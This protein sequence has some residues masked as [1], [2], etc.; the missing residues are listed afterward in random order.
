MTMIKLRDYKLRSSGNAK[1]QI[2][3]IPKSV[4]EEWNLSE[5]IVEVYKTEDGDI[6][7]RPKK[8]K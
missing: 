2:I 4:I 7:I 1:G 5:G 3:Q 8:C 6:V